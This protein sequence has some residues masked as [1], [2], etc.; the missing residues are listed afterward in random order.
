[1]LRCFRESD[2]MFLTIKRL[3]SSNSRYSRAGQLEKSR[4]LLSTHTPHSSSLE[5][6]W[7]TRGRSSSLIKIAMPMDTERELPDFTRYSVPDPEVDA[8]HVIVLELAQPD[9]ARV[10]W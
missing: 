6:C 8:W 10:K 2:E 3:H 7:E 4:K 9:V 1:M 5:R